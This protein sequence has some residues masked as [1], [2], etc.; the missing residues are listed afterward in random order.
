MPELYHIAIKHHEIVA[1]AYSIEGCNAE[2]V[3]KNV[4]GIICMAVTSDVMAAAMRLM[5]VID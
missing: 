4:I 3:R 2:R 5:S 1:A